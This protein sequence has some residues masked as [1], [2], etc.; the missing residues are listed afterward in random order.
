MTM[1]TN[2]PNLPL[3]EEFELPPNLDEHD[4]DGSG[5]AT[6][7]LRSEGT[8]AFR[9]RLD[10]ETRK[11]A[12]TLRA[13]WAQLGGKSP[14]LSLMVR[15]ALAADLANTVTVLR[16]GSEAERRALFAKLL[17]GCP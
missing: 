12:A 16:D 4:E 9:I 7:Y 10:D 5:L 13:T 2:T 17:A 11:V 8:E 15:R 3:P 6:V 1:N 14:S